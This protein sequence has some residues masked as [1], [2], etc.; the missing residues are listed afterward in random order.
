[1]RDSSG[2]RVVETEARIPHRDSVAV[3]YCEAEYLSLEA[4]CLHGPNVISF[5]LVT[6]R[7]WWHVVGCYISPDDASAVEDAAAAIGRR[8]QGDELLVDGNFNANLAD[9][10][11]M[12]RTE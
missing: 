11:R 4:L 10:E 12:S 6:G 8:P 1:M 7:Q 3:F 2:Y 9:T 5:Q